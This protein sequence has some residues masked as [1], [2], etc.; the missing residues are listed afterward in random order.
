MIWSDQHNFAPRF[1]SK[2]CNL[3]LS[4]HHRTMTPIT[5][6]SILKAS[7][8][9]HNAITLHGPPLRSH[10]CHCTICQTFHGAPFSL[11]AI[12]PP[13]HVVL[14]DNH[15]EVFQKH[16]PKDQLEIYRCRECGTLVCAWV[17]RVQR[18][19]VYVGVGISLNGKRIKPNENPEFEG[20]LH[21]FYKERQRDIRY[22]VCLPAINC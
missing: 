16:I 20:L 3:G 13:A 15:H 2:I 11:N 12:Y 18:W 4:P 14:P 10:Y 1:A 22:G 17:G 5:P 19:A 7:C 9:C 8:L 6:D 21:M